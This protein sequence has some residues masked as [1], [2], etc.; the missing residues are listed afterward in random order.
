MGLQSLV[1][2][3]LSKQE[4]EDFGKWSFGENYEDLIGFHKLMEAWN[5]RHGNKYMIQRN[6]TPQKDIQNMIDLWRK[7]NTN[8]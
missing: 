8:N 7:E 1:L 3:Y 2:N 6:S 4:S 5:E